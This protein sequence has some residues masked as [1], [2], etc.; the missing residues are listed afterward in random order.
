MEYNVDYFINKFT[1]IPA[2]N[3]CVGYY[4][5]DNGKRDVLGHCGHSGFLDSEESKALKTMFFD[6]LKVSPSEVN[7]GVNKYKG[8]NPKDRI[9]EALNEIA[10]I[11]LKNKAIKIIKE[12]EIVN[13]DNKDGY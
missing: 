5:Q 10:N 3:W 6:Y 1:D 12:I 13:E 4:F 8:D 7:D 11:I 2:E 9:L